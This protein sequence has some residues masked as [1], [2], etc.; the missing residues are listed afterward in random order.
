MVDEQSIA[1]GFI[2]DSVQDMCQGLAL[3]VI[4]RWFRLKEKAFISR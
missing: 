1:D 3:N 2:D 4:S